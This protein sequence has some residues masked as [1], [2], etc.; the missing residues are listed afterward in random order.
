LLLWSDRHAGASSWVHFEAARFETRQ[1]AGL[2]L[3]ACLDGA[4]PPYA[5]SQT[6]RELSNAGVYAAGA[7]AVDRNAWARV[8]AR[9]E[10]AIGY[11]DPVPI[12]HQVILASTRTRINALVNGSLKGGDAAAFNTLVDRLKL[13]QR[14][15]DLYGDHSV[16]WKPFSGDLAVQTLLHELRAT[17]LERG[18]VRFRWRAADSLFEASAA[19]RKKYARALYDEPCIVVVDAVSLFDPEVRDLY[20]TVL[21]ECLSNERAAVLMLPPM[22]FAE[23][24]F[25]RDNLEN[26][27]KN[28]SSK[29]IESFARPGCQKHAATF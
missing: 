22:V 5:E 8:I 10:E 13:K 21:D 16:D 28:C 23:R 14:R 26:V 20:E 7:M 25:L 4:Y 19:T 27:A 1:T 2:K 12:V 9:I 3:Q 11:L 17:I 6:V 24:S 18:A 29:C 15:L